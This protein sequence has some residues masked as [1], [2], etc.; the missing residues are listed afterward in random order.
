MASM[1]PPRSI[2]INSLRRNNN[3][4]TTVICNP[5]DLVSFYSNNRVLSRLPVSTMTWLSIQSRG[6]S[7]PYPPDTKAFLYYFTAKPRIAGELRLQ[8]T[9]SDDP[10]SCESGSDLLRADG[11]TWLRPLY[12]HSKHR[13]PLH[14]KLK[15]DQLV[16]DDMDKI[17]LLCPQMSSESSLYTKWRIYRQLQ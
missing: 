3:V 2:Q 8:V 4:F 14:E 16:P 7:C 15:E 13:L 1:S 17:C 10:A 11:R 5:L 6:S 12:A 9:S